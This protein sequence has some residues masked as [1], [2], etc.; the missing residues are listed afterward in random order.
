[1]AAAAL[2]YKCAEVAYMK[3]AY[4]KHPS[5]SK[6]RHELQAALD[7]ALPGIIGEPTTSTS[8]VDNPNNQEV[9]EKAASRRA[10]RSPQLASSFVIAARNRPHVK[11]LLTYTN[12]LNCAF[13]ATN[14]SRNALAAAS[15]DLDEDRV[16]SLF[17][18]REVL[19]FNFN[20]VERLLQ[21]VRVSLNSIS[22]KV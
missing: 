17:L 1:M 21:L 12:Y 19:D 15:I 22:C 16:A 5:A 9:L 20:N 7:A 10:T 18:I 6:D 13:E 3:V 4:F 11:R 8:D 2:A 14:K